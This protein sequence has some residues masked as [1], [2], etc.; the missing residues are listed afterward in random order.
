MM[1]LNTDDLKGYKTAIKLEELED[2]QKAVSKELR[3]RKAEAKVRTS[4]KSRQ[5]NTVSSSPR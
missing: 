5:Q 4:L 2:V 3:K 1:N